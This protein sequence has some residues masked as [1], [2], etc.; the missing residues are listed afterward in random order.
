MKH[1]DR[2]IG[3]SQL[4]I[5]SLRIPEQSFMKSPRIQTHSHTSKRVYDL[6]DP[7]SR[8]SKQ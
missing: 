2:Y 1:L 6:K 4:L 7:K 8:I 3:E 5:N